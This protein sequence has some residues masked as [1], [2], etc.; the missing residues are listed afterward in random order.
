MQKVRLTNLLVDGEE[1][2][3]DVSGKLLGQCG[4]LCDTHLPSIKYLSHTG[5]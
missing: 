4:V 2:E 5:L 3:S 1:E